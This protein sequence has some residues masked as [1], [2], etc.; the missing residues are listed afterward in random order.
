[1]VRCDI[2]N[3]YGYRCSAQAV[4]AVYWQ[5]TGADAIETCAQHAAKAIRQ[6][7]VQTNGGFEST[8]KVQ[9]YR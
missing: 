6:L 5:S 8:F 4:F 2:R 9:V 1:M 3:N 7:Q